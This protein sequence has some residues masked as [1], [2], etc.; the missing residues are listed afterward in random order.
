MKKDEKKIFEEGEKFYPISEK[1][2]KCDDK[3]ADNYTIENWAEMAYHLKEGKSRERYIELMKKTEYSNFFEG[4]NYEYGINKYPKDINKAF[5]IYKQSADNSTD[6]MSMFRMYYIYKNDFKTFNINKRNRVLEKFYLFKCYS[7]LRYPI[8]DREQSLLNR[9]NIPYVTHTHF[10]EEDEDFEIFHRYITFLKTNYKLYNI[11]P[12]DLIIIE[13]VIE[14][15]LNFEI[16]AQDRD[17]CINNL[18]NLVKKFNLEALYKLTCFEMDNNDEETEKRFNFL[19]NKE[20]YR[21]YIDYALYLN[22][23]NN[24]KKALEILNIAKK[25]GMVSAGLL[26]YDIFLDNVDFSVFINE[27]INSPFS[28][29]NEL[30]NLFQ[31]LIDDILTESVYSFFEFIFLRKIF[32]KH[33]GFEQNFNKYFYDYLKEI[34]N[35]LMKIVGDTNDKNTEEKKKIINKYF[36]GDENFKE[37][38]LACG[39]LYYYGIN[40]LVNIDLNKALN[41][42]NISYKNSESH[43]Y[44]RFCFYFIHRIYKNMYENNTKQNYQY[45]SKEYLKYE[46]NILYNK[47]ISS[48]NGDTSNL[49]S[50]YFYYLS[51]LLHE[52]IGNNG[53][54]LLE[55]ICLKRAIEYKNDS[56]GSGSIISIYRKN[57]SKLLLKK[58]EN[59]FKEELNNIIISDSEGYGEDGSLCPI[60]FENK[61]N[62]V[63]LPCKHLFCEFCISKLTKC[64]ICRGNILVKHLIDQYK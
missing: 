38:N 59:E 13:S 35:F 20:Y 55:F 36:C 54:K 27:S 19:F 47:Y 31:I 45:I 7:F 17:N 46:E 48:I 11:N 63:A 4:L 23:K 60:C 57:K 16:E 49:S 15:K 14:Y 33:Y 22:K 50:S 40:N 25:K 5:Q 34:V 64:P 52:K 32:V 10:K 30:F 26:Y 21:S 41:H 37:L 24:Y 29:D 43:S 18:K 1:S 8:I 2:K 44:K 56:P 28:Y 3:L 61:R 12:D 62:K 9:F 42:F 51:R 58:Y 39:T 6:S 53:N